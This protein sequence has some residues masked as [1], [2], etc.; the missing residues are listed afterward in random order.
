MA[1]INL[2]DIVSGFNLSKINDNFQKI[3]TALNDNVL[4]R[5]NVE[6]EPNQMQN[7]LDMNGQRIYNLPAP[8]ADH[9]PARKADLDSVNNPAKLLRVEDV[10]IP[11]FP[12]A[13]NRRNRL[14]SFDNEGNP[15][16]EFPSNDS[17]TALRQAIQTPTG[18][19]PVSGFTSYSE[20][21]AYTGSATT[22][23]IIRKTLSGTFDRDP[24]DTTSPDN[25]GTIIIDG[26][27]IRWKRRFAD[28]AKI[29]WWGVGEDGAVDDKVLI[30]LALNYC[31][32][33]GLAISFAKDSINTSGGHSY[34]G[35]I[36]SSGS[37]L[38]RTAN[39]SGSSPILELP[40]TSKVIGKLTFDGN[41]PL[42]VGQNFGSL[43]VSGDNVS[44]DELIFRNTPCTFT[45]S[46]QLRGL[47]VTGDNF[48]VNVLKGFNSGYSTVQLQ[49]NKALSS[50]HIGRLESYNHDFKAFV[51]NGSVGSV[52]SIV[53]DSINTLTN[54]TQDAS[55]CILI[56][57]GS[58]KSI[59]NVKSV[60][61]GYAK[62][63]GAKSQP[64][65]L[66]N[67]ETFTFGS[68][69]LRPSVSVI[70]AGSAAR[71]AVKNVIGDSITFERQWLRLFAE[72]FNVRS[73][74]TVDQTN[75]NIVRADDSIFTN[76]NSFT[77]DKI[78]VLGST[79]TLVQVLG[80]SY[81]NS[82]TLDI[83]IGDTLCTKDIP[84]FG[85]YNAGT[86]TAVKNGSCVV[87]SATYRRAIENLWGGGV[88]NLLTQIKTRG[89]AGTAPP[90]VGIFVRGDYV[91]HTNA[92]VLTDGL[93]NYVT[94]GWICTTA[95]TDAAAV[96]T[97]D[98]LRL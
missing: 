91:Y 1:K 57:T 28:I 81:A 42:E 67:V 2:N 76:R 95:G 69:Y 17:A 32:S 18:S 50:F 10:N 23:R 22:V 37:V 15:T 63:S 6:G 27:G 74:V 40:N 44:A 88:L 93:G 4:W 84:L 12:N 78:Q 92:R 52:D 29:S 24:S 30:D 90:T 38:K 72:N 45:L 20:L 19:D 56:D 5:K 89:F 21:R 77:V 7:D 58:N 64:L 49:L 82:T 46:T 79:T 13:V 14:V 11:A 85:S 61:I 8:V 87:D 80:F 75:V 51:C 65:K 94:R 98:K 25:G 47:V 96:W 59:L 55:D 68:L 26:N 86:Q 53:F 83:D 16:V 3:A 60:H 9:E 70:S 31:S 62:L 48:N 39:Y 43:L 35:T 73:L 71:L 41:F 97:E 36:F 34:T 33:A 66:E 54:T